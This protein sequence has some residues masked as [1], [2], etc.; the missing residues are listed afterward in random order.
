[1]DAAG[2][3]H[4][5]EEPP[6]R[7]VSL[8]PSATETLRA[9][10][11]GDRLVGRTRFD[12]ADAIG[13]LPSVGRGL[14]PDMESLLALEPDMVIRFAGPSDPDTP[15][16]LDRAAIP[17]FAVRPDGVDDVREMIRE[18]GA[19]VG[20]EA[21]AASLVAD[22]DRG[23]AAVRSRVAGRDP[24]RVA[25]ILGGSPPWVAGSGTFI[26]ELL[27]AAGGINVFED[28]GDLY[29]PVSV[30]ALLARDVDLFVIAPGAELDRRVRDRAP[31]REAPGGLEAPGP[32]LAAAAAALARLLHPGAWP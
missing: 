31:A 22:M 16:R 7:I 13:H 18:L 11:A 29:A 12:T 9:L 6:G 17:H 1:M 24:V 23:I 27:E 32:E 25:Y 4:A 21:E 15:E 14:E 10:G 3:L 28:L 8:V 20:R 19:L 30:E 2:R 5:P 26:H